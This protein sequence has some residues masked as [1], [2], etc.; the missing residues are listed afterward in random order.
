M[1]I[2]SLQKCDKTANVFVKNVDRSITPK[3]F[4]IF[5]REFGDV[6]CSTLKTDENGDSLGYGYV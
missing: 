6:I 1:P 4:D 5:F 2:I 3:E